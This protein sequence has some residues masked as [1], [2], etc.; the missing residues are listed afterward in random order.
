MEIRILWN[1]PILSYSDC[2]QEKKL[3]KNTKKSKKIWKNGKINILDLLLITTKDRNN[4][5]DY[6]FIRYALIS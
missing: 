3:R 1:D 4:I 5:F 2:F 6:F